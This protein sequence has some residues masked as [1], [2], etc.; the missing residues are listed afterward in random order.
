MTKTFLPDLI[1]HAGKPVT[2]IV[3][4][5]SIAAHVP[6]PDYAVY[7]ATKAAVTTLSAMQ[8]SEIGRH[9]VRVTNVEP[10]LTDTDLGTHIDNP[11]LRAELQDMLAT[12]PPMTAGDVAD[13]VE[14]IVTRPPHVNLR[15]VVVLPT[16]QV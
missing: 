13:L 1:S 14:F 10:G 2:D 9:G 7:A 4:I 11:R 16:E 8:P 5:S 15:H 12:I 6:F 3:N